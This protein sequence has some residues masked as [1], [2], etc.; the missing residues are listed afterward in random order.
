MKPPEVGKVHDHGP[1]SVP[2]PTLQNPRK[3]T[4]RYEQPQTFGTQKPRHTAE[5]GDGGNARIQAPS[6]EKH[7][8]SNLLQRGQQ[9][10]GMPLETHRVAPRPLDERRGGKTAR[11]T[12]LDFLMEPQD[13]ASKQPWWE[14]KSRAQK[15]GNKVQQISDRGESFEDE[16]GMRLSYYS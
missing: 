1:K 4:L 16:K 8:L 9:S 5:V 6:H 10:R 11:L 13:G 3:Q 2:G 7:H 15:G 12:A 14:K